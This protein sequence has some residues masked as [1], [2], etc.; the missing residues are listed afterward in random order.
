V[1]TLEHP[2]IDGFDGEAVW[3]GDPRYDAGRQVWNAMHDKRPAVVLHPRS[4][5]DVAAAIAYARRHDLPLAVRGGGHG[6]PGYG[7]C[8]DGVVID[9]RALNTVTVDPH[10]RI[11]RVGGGALLGEVDRAT[12]THGLVVPAGVV[13]H[14]GVG[15][16][17][18]GG[19]VGRMMR[20]HG[21]TIDNLLEAE[22]VTADGRILR[23]AADEHPDLFWGLRGGGGNFG[24]VTEFTFR[25]HPLRKLL[26]LAMFHPLS[27][28]RALL[29]AAQEVM[30]Q[31][32]D[33]LM[34][35]AFVRMAYPQPWLPADRVDELGVVSFV[36]WSGH[37]AEGQE[38][39]AAI[40]DEVAPVAAAVQAVPWLALQTAADELYSHGKRSYFKAGFFDTL[41]G[42]AI[43]VLIEQG[44]E[45]TSPFTQL[46]IISMGGAVRRVD[47]AST[48]F[49]NREPGWVINTPA[50]WLDPA[51]DARHIAWSRA[52]YRRLEPFMAA[53][54]YVNFMDA[55]DPGAE[56]S[57]VDVTLG[58]TLER[59]R[60]IKR[61]Y[62]PDNV[63][64]LNQNI[65]PSA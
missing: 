36:E 34:W 54:S 23:A 25:A 55:D 8:D 64:R 4:A 27:Q 14:T 56:R 30:A 40:R 6:V 24:V 11:A 37:P 46:E 43:D 39:L 60:E 41:T 12:Q 62:D 3:P 47:P 26:V 16:L 48:A 10:A 22:V 20:R 63:F 65:E 5:L 28:G 32:P 35:N 38:R 31:A 17:A 9:L 2:P 51:E 13:S 19:G 49:P 50:T 52:T 61:A 57:T 44:T 1:E 42:P 45:I 18:L 29:S 59:L 21:L 33:A 53:G 58:A 7:V 15:G